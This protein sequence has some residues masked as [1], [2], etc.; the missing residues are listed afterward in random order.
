MLVQISFHILPLNFFFLLFEGK[1]YS[2][3]RNL[4]VTAWEKYIS[5][6]FVS[7][8]FTA[9]SF[10][11]ELPRNNDTGVSFLPHLL[12][13]A[14]SSTSNLSN[15]PKHSPQKLLMLLLINEEGGVSF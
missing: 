7:L 15:S 5:L 6:V 13:L 9:G 4:L 8:S 12:G 11:S 3:S 2:L 1:Y 14:F 10:L